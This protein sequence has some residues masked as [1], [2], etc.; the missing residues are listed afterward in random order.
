MVKRGITEVVLLGFVVIYCHYTA[1]K[2]MN[3]FYKNLYNTCCN[4]CRWGESNTRPPD[5]EAILH[6]YHTISTA[7]IRIHY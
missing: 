4:W 1:T 2:L 6:R 5:Y 7:I 3:S